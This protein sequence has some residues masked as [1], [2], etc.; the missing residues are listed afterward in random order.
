MPYSDSD[1]K[2]PLLQFCLSHL[3]I[4][5][6]V[7]IGCGAGA[8]ADIIRGAFPE[9]QLRGIEPF[10]PYRRLFGLQ[11]K[12][13]ELLHED[14]RLVP[15]VFFYGTDLALWID[16][17]EHLPVADAE[18]QL[19]RIAAITR[20]G[21]LAGTP[22]VPFGQGTYWGNTQERHLSQWS[23]EKWYALGA[24]QVWLGE[25]TGLFWLKNPKERH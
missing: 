9:C 10:V 23:V 12:Y 15:D 2:A 14:V 21:V 19:H 18:A 1:N 22:V 13:N 5:C 6:A 16:G 7:D 17:P 25:Q 3:P 24:E 8:I 4:H 11:K 20:L